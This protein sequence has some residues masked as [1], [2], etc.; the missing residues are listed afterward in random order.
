MNTKVLSLVYVCE[1]LVNHK[2]DNTLE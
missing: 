2:K 1:K